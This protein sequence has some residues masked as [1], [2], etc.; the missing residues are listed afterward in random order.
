MCV[1]MYYGCMLYMFT[2]NLKVLNFYEYR[3]FKQAFNIN[4]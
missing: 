1:F 3:N 2:H 4:Y